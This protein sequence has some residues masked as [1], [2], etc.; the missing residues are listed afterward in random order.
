MRRILIIILATAL[1]LLAVFTVL[2]E[3]GREI[4]GGDPVVQAGSTSTAA[5]L[6]VTSPTTATEFWRLGATSEAGVAYSVTQGRSI[7]ATAEFHSN[8]D[9]SDVYY[10]FPAPGT[11]RTVEAARFYILSR[12]GTYAGDATLML[13]IFDHSGTVRHTASTTEVDLET[14]AT[15]VWTDITLCGIAEN[16]DIGAGEFL[17]FHF[18]LNSSPGGDLVVHPL[19]EVRV[20][21]P[22]SNL[23]FMPLVLKE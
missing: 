18:S 11:R 10:I 23:M 16:L 21:R 3:N 12:S 20:T 2:A 14:V 5:P 17:A 15:G 1:L 22:K 7:H 9:T 8:R 19:F 13:E 4:T 6:A